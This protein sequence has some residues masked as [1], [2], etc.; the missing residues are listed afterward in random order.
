MLPANQLGFTKRISGVLSLIAVRY[1]FLFANSSW[2]K[3]EE[4]SR[5]PHSNF[6][7]SYSN[8]KAIIV[9]QWYGGTNIEMLFNPWWTSTP[10]LA[11]IFPIREPVSVKWFGTKAVKQTTCSSGCFH[12][13][14]QNHVKSTRHYR[15]CY[16][17][18]MTIMN[19]GDCFLLMFH[20]VARGCGGGVNSTTSGL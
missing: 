2:V 13:C 18:M 4:M 20:A 19:G 5:H 8:A 11:I 16:G 17:W 15:P 3:P 12:R 9:C 1:G 6:S 14:A 7:N 10:K